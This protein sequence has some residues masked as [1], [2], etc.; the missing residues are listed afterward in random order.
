MTLDLEMVLGSAV[1]IIVAIVGGV[2]SMVKF[3]SSHYEKRFNSLESN[4][5]K[6][7]DD[8]RDEVKQLRSDMDSMR[9][10]VIY[11]TIRKEPISKEAQDES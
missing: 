5:N 9:V 4:L 3:T 8:V 1:V 2:W 6:R 7:V 11:E 10:A